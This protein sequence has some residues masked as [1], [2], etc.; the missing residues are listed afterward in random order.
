MKTLIKG[1]QFGTHN[2]HKPYVAGFKH[3]VTNAAEQ[4]KALKVPMTVIIGDAD[5]NTRQDRAA[6]L[7]NDG[8]KLNVV[9]AK[10]GGEL[11]IFTH[12]ELII[13]TVLSV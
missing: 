6:S 12:P 5:K 11:L 10:D 9:L 2:S 7:L 3:V 13:D 1:L 8:V 4:M